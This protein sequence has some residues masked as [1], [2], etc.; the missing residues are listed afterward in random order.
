SHCFFVVFSSHFYHFIFCFSVPDTC[1]CC[2]EELKGARL[3]DAPVCLPRPLR[4]AHKSRCSLVI[5]PAESNLD[6]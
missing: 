2:G 3:A 6:R 1:P 5:A 4:H